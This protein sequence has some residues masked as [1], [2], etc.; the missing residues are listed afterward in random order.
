MTEE[1]N[2]SFPQNITLEDRKT[3]TVTGVNDIGGYDEQTVTAVTE[4]GELTIKGEELRIVRMSV[5]MGELVVEGNIVS[6]MYS[7][8]QPKNQ[9]FL[10]KLFR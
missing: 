5:E 2:I 9:G 1:K 8:I 4:L 3:L 7:E 6:L 10:S